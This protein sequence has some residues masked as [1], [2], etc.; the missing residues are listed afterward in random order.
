MH[1]TFKETLLRLP[2]VLTVFPVSRAAWYDGVKTGRY[3]ASVKLASRA[4]AWRLSDV[5]KLIEDLGQE[6]R[7]AN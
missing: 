2:A 5:E 7:N 1:K 6:G 3:P 4:V